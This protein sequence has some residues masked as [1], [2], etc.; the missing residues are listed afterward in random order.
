MDACQP[1]SSS[2][3]EFWDPSGVAWVAAWVMMYSLPIPCNRPVRKASSTLRRV[4]AATMR[5]MEATAMLLF[6]NSV[7]G[8]AI[9]RN[10][11]SFFICCIA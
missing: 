10:D 8:C 2:N 5:L 6:H 3:Q 11:D 4:R 9:D 7:K 1:T